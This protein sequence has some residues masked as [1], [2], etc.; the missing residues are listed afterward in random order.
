MHELVTKKCQIMWPLNLF[1]WNL[2]END[3]NTDDNQLGEC[4]LGAGFG[5]ATFARALECAFVG[6]FH[7]ILQPFDVR[8]II[9]TVRQYASVLKHIKI[10]VN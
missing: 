10:T 2:F 7:V 9:V 8:A 4:L 3:L 5:M 1:Q 6:Q